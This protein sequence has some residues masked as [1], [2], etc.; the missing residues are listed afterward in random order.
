MTE[1]TTSAAMN[2][3]KLIGVIV[4][5]VWLGAMVV[6]L[7]LWAFSRLFLADQITSFNDTMHSLKNPPPVIVQAPPAPE[8]VVVQAAPVV[9][10][11]KPAPVKTRTEPR[12]V[13]QYY[14]QEPQY[15]QD[16]RYDQYPQQNPVYERL[17]Q[18]RERSLNQLRTS[19][20]YNRLNRINAPGC[21]GAL[22][23]MAG[24]PS[25]QNDALVSRN[26]N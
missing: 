4:L 21:E 13:Q 3:A 22:M 6:V 8:P 26:C 12:Q 7:T 2:P 17:E 1:R 16:P 20:G 10:A 24:N 9:A 5:G 14:P 11:P 15:A 25:K 19:L 18:S 23:Q